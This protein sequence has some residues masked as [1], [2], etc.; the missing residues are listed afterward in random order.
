M[1]LSVRSKCPDSSPP[2]KFL[3]VAGVLLRR[4]LTGIEIPLPCRGIRVMPLI[5]VI[6][7]KF[8]SPPNP[9][10]HPGFIRSPQTNHS[11]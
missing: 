11:P 5:R 4:S 7:V 6:D 10:L 9:I 1:E 3:R 2:K 8:L